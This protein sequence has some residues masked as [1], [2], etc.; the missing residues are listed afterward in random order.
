MH[1]PKPVTKGGLSW[2][3]TGSRREIARRRKYPTVED[4]R[5][6][7]RRR[8]PAFGFEYVDCG[9]GSDRGVQ[10]NREALAAIELVPRYGGAQVEPDTGVT[11][12]GRAYA[13]PFGVAPMGLPGLMWPGAE[14]HLARAAQRAR[15]PYTAGTVGGVAMERLAAIAPDVVWF[16]LYR[17]PE[18]DH[19]V[20]LDLVRRAQA[21]GAHVLV[22]TLDV[23]ARS[24][25]PR[26]LRNGLIVPFR[27]SA[28]TVY[29]AAT[30]PAWLA[31]LLR[32]GQPTFANLAPYAGA[33]AR[34]GEIAGFTRREVRGG[35][36]WEE[37]RRYRDAWRGP[38]AV[39]GILHPDDA[40]Q[41]VAA[42]VDGIEVSNHGGRQLDG[43]PPAI[44]VLPAI[45][46]AVG[47][48]ATVLYDGGIRCG[49]DAVRALAL[50]AAG[51]LVGRPFL[52]AL[53]ALGEEGADYV[54]ALLLEEVRLA[55]RQLGVADVAAIRSL[56]RRHPGAMRFPQP[57]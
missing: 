50:G 57:R 11:L 9:E 6:G 30:S 53:G 15:I 24:K 43:A 56:A 17:L 37:V 14:L 51:T 13:A 42:G 2:G 39:K 52:F 32:H 25:R 46:A 47:E 26:E 29:E 31:A 54:T 41:A 19:A 28:R 27:L 35:F 38:L 23:P 7:A 49:L 40:R 8:V 45:V 3:V 4:L 1:E 10:R 34:R 20:G 55:M 36:T 16:Q 21:C 22:L 33:G 18:N 48:K 12:F 44:D 5:A